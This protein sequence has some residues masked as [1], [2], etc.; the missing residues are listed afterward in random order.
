[1]K[2]KIKKVKNLEILYMKKLKR[3]EPGKWNRTRAVRAALQT[4]A[5]YS[6]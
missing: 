2:S 5:S 6:D 1:M 3:R 4:N